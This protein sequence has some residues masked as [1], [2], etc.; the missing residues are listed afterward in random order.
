MLSCQLSKYF[1]NSRTR[2]LSV[3]KKKSKQLSRKCPAIL[4]LEIQHAKFAADDKYFNH[5]APD[6]DYDY[7]FTHLEHFLTMLVFI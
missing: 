2:F 1:W 4:L 3:L 6:D 5:F 7:H